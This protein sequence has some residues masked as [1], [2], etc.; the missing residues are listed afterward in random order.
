MCGGDLDQE[1]I[2]YAAQLTQRLAINKW[3]VILNGIT[4]VILTL[5]GLKAVNLYLDAFT[6]NSFCDWVKQLVR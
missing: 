6:P 2:G 4:P 1:A 3:I 5:T